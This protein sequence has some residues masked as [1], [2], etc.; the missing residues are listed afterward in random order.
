MRPLRNKKEDFIIG[1]VDRL[2]D[3]RWGVNEID[4][5]NEN[6]SRY[7]LNYEDIGMLLVYAYKYA[8]T[9]AM[10]DGVVT[11]LEQD[12]LNQIN[13]MYNYSY[14]PKSRYER[15]A[16]KVKILVLT[17]Q[18]EKTNTVQESIIL[19]DHYKQENEIKNEVKS[20]YYKSR[21]PRPKLTPYSNYGY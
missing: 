9:M 10:E 5:L 14:L 16:L 13:L 15:E 12:Q 18:Y 1:V 6:H 19:E 17:R 2:K 7:H 3:G 4:Y 8:Y 20:I 11:Q 21:Y